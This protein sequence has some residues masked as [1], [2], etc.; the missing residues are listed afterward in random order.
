MF[1]FSVL[2]QKKKQKGG[3]KTFKEKNIEPIFAKVNEGNEITKNIGQISRKFIE[4]DI[5]KK[6]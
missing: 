1:N 6:N 2:D 3:K 4:G 5:I